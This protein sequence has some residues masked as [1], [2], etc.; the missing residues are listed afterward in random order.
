MSIVD[1]TTVPHHL[2]TLAAW[3][4]AEW[5]YLNPG[6]TLPMR[7]AKMQA[8]LEEGLIP[9][10]FV[11]ELQGKLAGS[12]AIIACDM[13][14]RPQW[15]PWLASVFVAPQFRRQGI[16]GQLARHVMAQAAAAGHAQLHLFTP[17]R[18]AFYERLGWQAIGEEVYRGSPVSVMR[19]ELHKFET[20]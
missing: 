1:L 10:T 8:Y 16:G 2:P 11:F 7:I 9:T 4:Q 19:A 13:D 12:A 20:A 14:T 15:T 6:Q 17:D 3:H 5:A 18:A